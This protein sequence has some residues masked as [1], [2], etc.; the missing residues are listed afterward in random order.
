MKKQ[1]NLKLVQY[2]LRNILGNMFVVFFGVVFPILLSALISYGVGNEVPPSSR[3]KVITSIFISMSLI[4]PM[5]ILLIGYAV[6]YA[7]EL[8]KEIPLRFSLF[9]FNQNTLLAAKIIANLIFMTGAFIIYVIAEIILL[10]LQVPKLSS[11]ICLI[12]T[13][14]L[15]SVV[16]MVLAHGIATLLRKFGPTYAVVML[17]YFGFMILCGM[18]GMTVDSFPGWMQSLAKLFPMT[19]VS[20]DFIEFWQGGSYNFAP[21]IQS[22][23]FFGAVSF[24]I[25]I[26]SLHKNRRVIK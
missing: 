15:L 10:D 23:L 13:L 18:M 9:G 6:T 8:E 22:F 5:C 3:T 12:V 11:A 21:F 1:L 25:L 26:L 14:Y 20:T 16:F 19:Y 2:E 4:I 7:Q 24:I 17:L